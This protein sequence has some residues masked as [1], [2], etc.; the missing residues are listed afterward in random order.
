MVPQAIGLAA[1]AGLPPEQGIY[2]AALAPLATAFTSSSPG[3][4]SGPTALTS[5]L[6][7]GALAG[8]A[9]PFAPA[10]VGLAALLALEVGIIR[11]VL[12]ALRLGRVAYLMSQPV[13]AGFTAAAGVVIAF[14]QLPA[15]L[16]LS[17]DASRPVASAVEALAEP[18]SWN[19]GSIAF[20]AVTIALVLVGRRVHPLFPGVL[21][22]VVGGIAAVRFAGIDVPTVG[23]V[24]SGAPLPFLDLPW[25]HAFDL[26][27]PAL[28]IAIVGFAEPASIARHYASVDRRA[29]DPDRELASQGLASLVAGI[30]RSYPV[31]SSF[32]RSALNRL[33]G[34]TSR[35]SG[36][37]AG[38]TVLAFL[39]FAS[40]IEP[41]PR[42]V[43]AAI[44]LAAVVS[45]LNP[46][47]F[48]EYRRLARTQFW[49]AIATFAATILLA[50]RV[51]EGVLIGIG[52]GI[53]AHLWREVRVPMVERV[54][55]DVLHVEPHGV[56]FFAS[57]P[58]LQDAVT[59]LVAEHPE[60]RHVV[61]HLDG[62]GRI[63]LTGALV[64]R[65]LAAGIRAS[66]LTIEVVDVPPQAEKVVTRTLAS[67]PD[68]TV[69]AE[70]ASNLRR[71][72]T[73]GD[74]RAR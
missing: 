59:R 67:S 46:A 18:S 28:T 10:Y 44:I 29:W 40:I 34:G 14:S 36:V 45:L 52:V 50:P 24:P 7:L 49:V 68:V 31:G 16:G 58:A 38:L 39:P 54:V 8:L 26:L 19:V 33:A 62:L 56:L 32:S 6:T 70:D 43:M 69:V 55:G 2:A 63:D 4:Q 11:I 42:S 61:L 20:A 60:V 3:L 27:L 73:E 35:W 64:L 57:A 51:D 48:R 37:V 1:L 72:A 12:G 13:V 74:G 25:S 21:I 22:A 5:L 53:A 15:A 47:P 65:D 41:L 17:G 9:V 66:G 30:F 71:R 23:P